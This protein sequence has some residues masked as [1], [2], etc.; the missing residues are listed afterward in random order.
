E[1]RRQSGAN[2][3][4]VIESV[5]ANLAKISSQLPSARKVEVIRDRS[6]SIY[7]ALHEI[8]LHLILGSI[9]ASLVVF[10]F[11]RNWRST[12]IA[13]VAIPASVL[14]AC[15]RMAAVR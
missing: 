7:A 12:V 15:G 2:T 4:A 3:V 8:N 13:A 9:L 5:K 11:M 6:R 10:A 1:I 14:S